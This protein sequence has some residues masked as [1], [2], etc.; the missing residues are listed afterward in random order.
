MDKV[1]ILV[2][3]DEMV[4]AMNLISILE[5]LGYDVLEPANSFEEAIDLLRT[6]HPDI[7]LLDIQLDGDKDGIDL[8]KHIKL[9]HEIPFIFLTSNADL[10]TLT[11]A[12]ETLPSSYLV[13]PF[14]QDDLFTSIEIAL[15][16][17][18]D[19]RGNQKQDKNIVIQD[20]IFIKNKNM[21]YKVKFEDILFIKSD[22]V[23]LE[24]FT[25]GNKKHLI[26]GSLTAF[27]SRLPKNFFRTHRSYLIN[28]DFLDA[29]NS[30]HVVIQNIQVPI[31]KTYRNDLMS[32]IQLE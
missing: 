14:N 10:S 22:H 28:L 8:A 1:R 6:E 20:S 32:S 15:Y 30:I 7:A 12:K 25:K 17:F 16:N 29:I 27:S 21:F 31:G 9:H 19:A 2:V 24:V 5:G 26:R 4:I 18:K 23:Y 3:E 11:Q 13:K